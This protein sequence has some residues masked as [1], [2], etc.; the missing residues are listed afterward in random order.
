MLTRTLIQ[1]Q[2]KTNALYRRQ[3]L[4]VTKR[5]YDKLVV[6]LFD[7]PVNVGQMD[8]DDPKVGTG[9][10]GHP[11]C[12]DVL[13]LQIKVDENNIVRDAKFLTFGCGSAIASSSLAT[14]WVIGKTLEECLA[15]KNEDISKHLSLPPVKRHCSVLAEDAIR[16]AVDDLKKKST[17]NVEA[18]D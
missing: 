2:H 4:R 17:D 11:A 10:R 9:F 7:N 5:T 14:T 6:D 8:K 12:G 1:T 15:I 3:N 16:L 13:Q 18:L